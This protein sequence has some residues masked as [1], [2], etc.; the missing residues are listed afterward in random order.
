MRPVVDP[1][2]IEV[3][4][5]VQACHPEGKRVLEVG[6]GRGTFTYQYS[7]LPEISIGFDPALPELKIALEHEKITANQ[8]NFI[9]AKGEA[10][11]F[12]AGGFDIVVFASSL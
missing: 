8:P 10:M 1:E 4:H 6:C 9:C 7:T 11:P 2:R 3:N 5:F 12:P